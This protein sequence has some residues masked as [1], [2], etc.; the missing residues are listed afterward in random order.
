M[1]S[2]IAAVQITQTRKEHLYVY[3]HNSPQLYGGLPGSVRERGAEKNSYFFLRKLV[4]IL[5]PE[6]LSVLTMLG[7]PQLTWHVKFCLC[8]LP[9]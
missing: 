6:F 3:F 5:K 4:I 9:V 1:R 8:V 2:V 7:M